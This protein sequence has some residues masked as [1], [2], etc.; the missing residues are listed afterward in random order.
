[1]ALEVLKTASGSTDA[2]M[3]T[4]PPNFDTKRYAAEWVEESQVPMKS[5]RQILQGAG[6]TADGWSIWRAESKSKATEVFG[7]GKKKFVLMCRPRQIQ[8]QVNAVYGNISK[9]HI[10]NEV[11]GATAAGQ[12]PD[13]GILTE[14]RLRAV[15]K[16][17]IGAEASE[18]SLNPVGNDNPT[19]ELET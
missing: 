18:M 7:S 5:Q 19:A 12:A 1:M 6:L 10:N 13:P 8:Q 3:F 11:S 14:E 17:G 15:E 16:V 9:Q 2:G 4:L